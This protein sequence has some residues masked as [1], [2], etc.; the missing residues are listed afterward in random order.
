MNQSD[1]ISNLLSSINLDNNR[2][3]ETICHCFG[4]TDNVIRIYAY[5]SGKMDKP[6]VPETSTRERNAKLISYNFFSNEVNYSY[7]REIKRY[8]DTQEEAENNPTNVIYDSERDMPGN[9]YYNRKDGQFES[10]CLLNS[11]GYCNLD[12]WLNSNK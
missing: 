3:Y 4:D 6:E 12:A 7:I 11:S 5:L 8:F 2:V 9:S 1:F 10:I